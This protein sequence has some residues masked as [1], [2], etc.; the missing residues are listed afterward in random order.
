M[1]IKNLLS[2]RLLTV[3]APHDVQVS[4]E[5]FSGSLDFSELLFVSDFRDTG[6]VRGFFGLMFDELPNIF[7]IS[8]QPSSVLIYLAYQS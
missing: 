4:A 6:G 1:F 5:S 8:W 3:L 2:Q 7:D